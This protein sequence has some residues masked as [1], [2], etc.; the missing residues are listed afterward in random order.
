MLMLLV[1]SLSFAGSQNHSHYRP[2]TLLYAEYVPAPYR[3]AFISEVTEMAT[4]LKVQPEW[5]MVVMRFETGSSFRPNI[6]NKYSGAVGLIQ[7]IPTTASHLG[8][9]TGHLS[10]LSAVEQLKWV[11]K[12][13][14]PYCG[15]MN[16]PYDVYI[17]V[18][19]PRFLG[20]PD[21][22]VLYRRHG[23]TALDRRRY[24]Y[25]RVLDTNRDGLITITDVK[26]QIR[27]FVPE[28]T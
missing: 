26:S 17:V 19:A 23:K 15:R 11:E 25:N 21:H 1:T 3:A 24:S 12:Y 22:T 27:R 14:K 16:N 10:G 18:F 6:R 20:C 5:L 9:T 8:T 4:R 7:F 2:K 13:F 28:T